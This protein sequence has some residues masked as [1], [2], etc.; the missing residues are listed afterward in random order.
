M[1]F[2]AWLPRDGASAGLSSPGTHRAWRRRP[3][4]RSKAAISRRA[5]S[6]RRD[7]ARPLAMARA[8]A[9]L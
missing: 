5:G 3:A 6:R 9:K 1:R 2:G 4:K 8:R 7:S